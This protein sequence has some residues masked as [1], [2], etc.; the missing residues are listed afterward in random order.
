ME[1]VLRPDRFDTDPNSSAATQ[2]WKHWHK[3]FSNYIEA[4][5]SHDPNKL[6]VLVNFL[7]PRIYAYISDCSTYE[8][9]LETLSAL[10]IKPK[11]EVFARHLLASRR[12]KPGETLDEFLQALKSLSADCNFKAV[13]AERHK[14]EF[15]RDAFIS[16]LRSQ[17]IRQR[18]LENKTLELSAAFDQAR[19]L[20]VAQQSLESYPVPVTAAAAPSHYR[21]QCPHNAS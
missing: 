9:A 8:T 1:R 6:N 13:T 3:T 10:Y 16:G 19:A 20:D 12:Q 4:I 5:S 17:Q 11:N 18:L 21:T 14:E 15:I 2:E 7:S